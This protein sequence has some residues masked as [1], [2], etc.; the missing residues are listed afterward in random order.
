MTITLDD[1]LAA[2]ISLERGNNGGGPKRSDFCRNGHDMSI[3]GRQ[4]MKVLEDGREVKNGRYC[5][6]CKRT[7][8]RTPGA[9]E[10]PTSQKPRRSAVERAA[11]PSASTRL[12][13]ARAARE[14]QPEETA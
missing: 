11:A 4:Q 13:A 8:Q 3:H 2:A 6:P 10:R 5:L 9:P 12:R 7:R 14:I 1:I